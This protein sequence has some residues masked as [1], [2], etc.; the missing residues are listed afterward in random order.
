M[1]TMQQNA[2]KVE[3]STKVILTIQFILVQ[4]RFGLRSII[5]NIEIIK[6]NLLSDLV[7]LMLCLTI[8]GMLNITFFELNPPRS[9]LSSKNVM[10]NSIISRT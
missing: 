7:Q 6:H 3:R 8:T 5:L 10:F 9:K 1:A 4:L 2:R